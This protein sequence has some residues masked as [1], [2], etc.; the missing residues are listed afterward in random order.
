MRDPTDRAAQGEERHGS[1][2]RQVQRAGQG[3]QAKI[4]VRSGL[5]QALGFLRD[6]SGQRH[7]G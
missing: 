6:R 4:D 2:K 5:D 7:H 3:S 1:I